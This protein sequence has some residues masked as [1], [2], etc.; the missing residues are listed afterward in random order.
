MNL[1]W[2]KRNC[3]RS[4]ARH[5]HH[6]DHRSNVSQ[7]NRHN[8]SND[9][10]MGG[11]INYNTIGF[12][13]NDMIRN[14]TSMITTGRGG[15]F[16]TNPV[17]TKCQWFIDKLKSFSDCDPFAE[18][19]TIED[20]PDYYQIIHN[21][22][23]LTTMQGKISNGYYISF[24]DFEADFN[25]IVSNCFKYNGE[26]HPVTK[27]VKKLNDYFQNSLKKQYLYRC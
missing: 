4:S 17:L 3:V 11:N 26:K 22:M 16:R 18:P 24:R 2:L 1:E 21:P 27:M 9:N 8:N 12:N 7:L 14:G 20:A 13:I 15:R 25:L 5:H 10:I 19:V 6:H 23:D